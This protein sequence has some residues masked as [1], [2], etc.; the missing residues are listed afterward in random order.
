MKEEEKPIDWFTRKIALVGLVVAGVGVLLNVGNFYFAYW[1]LGRDR[2]LSIED[3]FWFR[4][5]ITPATIEP[6]LKTFSGLFEEVPTRNTSVEKQA[7]YALK[8]TTDFSKLYPAIQTLSLFNDSLPALI[9]QKLSDCE[10]ELLEYSATLS[11]P[12]STQDIPIKQLQINLWSK[13]NSIL[14]LVK[15]HHLKG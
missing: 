6:M 9:T 8:V 1:K 11:Q 13:L 7:A 10:D 14:R 12:N 3:E 5:I 4:K 2:R 15:E